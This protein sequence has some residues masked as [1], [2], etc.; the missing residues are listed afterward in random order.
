MICEIFI[1]Y[2]SLN[3]KGNKIQKVDDN[4]NNNNNYYYY[5]NNNNNYY[6]YDNNNNVNRDNKDNE[7]VIK[8]YKSFRHHIIINQSLI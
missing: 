5:D 7:I 2:Q 3:D 8:H 4:N 1:S 6:Y